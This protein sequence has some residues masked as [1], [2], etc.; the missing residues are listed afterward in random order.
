MSMWFRRRSTETFEDVLARCLAAI[1]TDGA[2]VESCLAAHPRYA[3]RLKPALKTAASLRRGFAATPDTAFA[4]RLRAKVL[5]AAAA[6]RPAP[7]A[8][9]TP[10]RKAAEPV[11]HARRA[12]WRAGVVAAAAAVFALMVFLPL[13]AVTSADALPGDWNYGFKRAT[14]EVQFKLGL[15]DHLD[16]ASER[17]DEIA[18][19]ARAGR[20]EEIE[21]TAKQYQAEIQKAQQVLATNPDPATIR[22]FEDEINRQK[23]ALKQ[24]ADVLDQQ[25][26]ITAPA[27]TPSPGARTVAPSA[28][29]SPDATP[30]PNVTP[31]PSATP[32][33][34][35][36]VE[37]SPSSTTAVPTATPAPAT[38]T[39]TPANPARSALSGAAETQERAAA[40][41]QDARQRALATVAPSPVRTQTPAASPTPSRTAAVV[42]P[43]VEPT[44][45]ATAAPAATPTP[46]PTAVPTIIPTVEPTTPASGTPIVIPTV[47][48]G[49]PVGPAA[50]RPAPAATEPPVTPA[51]TARP[52]V[53]PA[54]TEAPTP[55]Q[56]ATP[57]ATPRPTAPPTATA[58]PIPTVEPTQGP[59]RAAGVTPPVPPVETPTRSGLAPAQTQIPTSVPAVRTLATQFEPGANKF[60]YLGPDLP[61]EQALAMF[62]GRYTRAEWSPS[63]QPLRLEY[64]P[65]RPTNRVLTAGSLVTIYLTDAI[66][67]PRNSVIVPID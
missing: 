19:L 3:D 2:T 14:E 39:S 51:P 8:V 25:A 7:A 34:T 26:I 49:T 35:R 12:M 65:G 42:I 6:P 58:A 18:R 20:T 33:P 28:T 32:D 31:S 1:E 4:E 59:T 13:G 27:A 66:V 30:S 24:A 29:P 60:F 50:T 45:T 15:N 44:P 17:A 54:P 57:V 67:I 55:T 53:T 40:A 5:D 63:G 41:V 16:L 9:P 64:V 38:S 43:T 11:T 62:S 48:P 23:L 21:G 36:T 47:V 37:P 46:V 56:V 52:I 22:R 10:I 61:V